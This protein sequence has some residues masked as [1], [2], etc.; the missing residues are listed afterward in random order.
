ML[1]QSLAVRNEKWHFAGLPA[2]CPEIMRDVDYFP[3][4]DTGT[5]STYLI[6]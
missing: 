5:E 2:L 4:A 1:W 6:T 3:I